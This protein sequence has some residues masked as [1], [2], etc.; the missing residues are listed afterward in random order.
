MAK[1]TWDWENRIG[2]RVRLRDIH[3]LSAVV[4]AGSMAKAATHLATSQSAVSESIA[5]LEDALHVKL[6]D[7]SPQGIAPTIYADALLKRGNVVFDEIGQAIKDIEFLLDPTLGEVRIAAPEFLFAWLIPDAINETLREHP[8]IVVRA[9]ETNSANLEFPELRDRAVDL[10]VYRVPRGFSN[11]E[12]DI[13]VLHEDRHCVAVGKQSPWARRRKVTL[14]ELKDESWLIPENRVVISVLK[15]A[16]EA[17][18]LQLPVQRVATGSVLLRM[19]LLA[20]GRFLTVITESAFRGI[21]KQLPFKMLP[22]KLA[23]APPITIITLKNRTLSPVA[24]VF[25]KHLRAVGKSK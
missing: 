7:R 17:E 14:G 2:R 3:V 24:Q 20:T 15:E 11:D 6:L 9:Y 19:N 25:I 13:E 5:S 18:G 16:F 4:R 8:K 21:A 23:K 10:V 12:F 1:A 22:I